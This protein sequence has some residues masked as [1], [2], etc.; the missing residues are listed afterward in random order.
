M[1]SLIEFLIFLSVEGYFF[2]K[3]YNSR[4]NPHAFDLETFFFGWGLVFISLFLFSAFNVSTEGNMTGAIGSMSKTNNA[5]NS[6]LTGLH[7]ERTLSGERRSTSLKGGIKERVN[8][9]YLVMFVINVLGY[10]KFMPK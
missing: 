2:R 1:K 9:V 5:A 4:F 10:I 3:V 8:L 6:R 7:A